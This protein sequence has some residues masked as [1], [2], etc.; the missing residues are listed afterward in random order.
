MGCWLSGMDPMVLRDLIRQRIHDGRLPRVELIELGQGYGIG[1]ACDGCGS[2]VAWNQRMTVRMSRA[3]W[4]TI[5]L[6]D[7]CFQ[8]WDAERDTNGRGTT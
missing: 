5:R 2:I 3:D 8:V 1:Q 6:H 7:D 4:R